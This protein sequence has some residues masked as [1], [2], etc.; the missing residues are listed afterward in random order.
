MPHGTGD[1]AE[2]RVR[3][4][5]SARVQSQNGRSGP[6]REDRD[7][8]SVLPVPRHET[9]GMRMRRV[10]TRGVDVVGGP[11]VCP[12][13]PSQ[14]QAEAGT[15]DRPDHRARGAFPRKGPAKRP[16]PEFYQT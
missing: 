11:C 8:R 10:G 9:A 13:F 6:K 14:G 4:S 2:L 3:E 1:R 12:N 7:T 15:T 5:D 16:T